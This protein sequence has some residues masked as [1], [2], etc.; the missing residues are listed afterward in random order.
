MSVAVLLPYFSEDFPVLG[1]Y[2]S[3][4]VFYVFLRFFENPKNV[5][6]YVFFAL[7]YTFSGTMATLYVC[8]SIWKYGK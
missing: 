5:T 4:H 1:L 8:N 2:T 7:L 3:R 6:F